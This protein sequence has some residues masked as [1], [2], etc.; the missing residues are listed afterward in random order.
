MDKLKRK[1]DEIEKIKPVQ[2]IDIMCWIGFGATIFGLAA[3]CIAF[4][5]PFWIQTIPNSFNTFRNGGLWEVCFDNYMHHKDSLQ[6]RAT[7]T[8][9]VMLFIVNLMMVDLL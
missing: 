8:C 2:P 6:V 9:I 3:I 1:S 7:C 4:A 5:S